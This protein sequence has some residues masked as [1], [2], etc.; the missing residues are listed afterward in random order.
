MCTIFIYRRVWPD[1]SLV[2]VHNRDE[3]TA[4]PWQAPH[5]WEQ[6]PGTLA[7]RD[8]EAGGT[9][10]GMNRVPLTVAV[11][12]RTD[13][14]RQPKRPSRGLLAL[15]ALEASSVVG[16]EAGIVAETR[17]RG[18]NPFNMVVG[19][20][21]QVR[22]IS[23][24]AQGLQVMPLDDGVSVVTSTHGLNP[25]IL[26]P[27]RSRAAALG[28]LPWPDFVQSMGVLLAER[29]P[30]PDGYAVRKDLGPYGTVCASLVAL[31]TQPEF[32]FAPGPLDRAS[33]QRIPTS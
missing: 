4:R 19:D 8:L 3:F 13:R 17:R 29:T 27:L 31:G 28:Q 21:K 25:E 20:P 6:S 14:P 32:L 18:P 11:T 10:M 5:R 23:D 12:N 26:A 7:P 30:F 16:A 9:W 15:T 22:L 24:G 33:W 1:R 2:V